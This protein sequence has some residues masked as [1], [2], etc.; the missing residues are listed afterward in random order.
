MF[1][2]RGI[3]AVVVTAIIGTKSSIRRHAVV[4]VC[5]IRYQARVAV[6]AVAVVI[7]ATTKDCFDGWY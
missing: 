2:H 3:F 4:F 1:R 5:E 7:T 6:V